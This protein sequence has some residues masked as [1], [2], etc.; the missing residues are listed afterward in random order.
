MPHRILKLMG[1][2]ILASGFIATAAVAQDEAEDEDVLLEEITI[3]ATKREQ[4]IQDVPFT[5]QAVSGDDIERAGNIDLSGVIERFAGVEFRTS[6]PGTGAVAIRGI[7]ELNTANINGGTGA[8]VGL[9]VDEAPFTVAGLMPQAAVFDL[10][11][12]EVL[13]GP[14]GSLFGEG[15][16]GGTIRLVTN[17]PD[18]TK[19][20]ARVDYTIGSIENGGT[21]NQLNAMINIPLV[22]DKLAIRAVG[23]YHDIGGFIDRIKPDV[24]VNFGPGQ[25][26]AIPTLPDTDTTFTTGSIEEDAND[27]ESYGGRVQLEWNIGDGWRVNASAMFLDADRGNRSLGTL[28]R[29]R[30]QSTD[31]ESTDDE[32]QQYGL[33]I[34]K[35]T[36]FGTFLSSTSY[37]DRQIFF[38]QDQIGLVDVA[39]DFAFPL[40]TFVLGD[41]FFVNG[42]RSDLASG[43]EDFS[44]ELRFV[45]DF[46]GPFQMTLG[47]FYRNRD[48]TYD[49][50]T[51]TEPVTPA[52]VFNAAVGGPLFTE[53]GAGD[54]T[55]NT[56]AETQQIALFGEFTY[57]ITD[58]LT[59]LAGGRVFEEDRESSTDAF[60]V[61]IGAIPTQNF[62]TEASETLFTPRLSLSYDITDQITG[63][64][65]F[66]EGF[67]SGGQN[68]LNAFV[69]A[70]DLD[71]YLSEQVQTYELGLKSVFADGRVL[72]NIAGFY[73][74]W[75]NLQVVLAEGPGGAG[76][77]LGNA[78]SARS[79]G[80][81]AELIWQVSENLDFTAS[82]LVMET[83]IRDSVLTVPDPNGN[84]PDIPV[85]VGTDIPGTAEEQFSAF[86]NYSRPIN[87]SLSFFSRAAISYLGGSVTSLSAITGQTVQP[88]T[89]PGFTKV[90][91]RIGVEAEKWALSLF[92]DNLFDEDIILGTRAG[93]VARD[94]VT[95]D[96]VHV[97]GPPRVIGINLRL[98]Y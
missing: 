25:N 17:K 31:F 32:L 65:T 64:A 81:D 10:Q 92:A 56:V 69:P 67:R 85:P 98:N 60:G 47:G 95:G 59:L 14:Q 22:E 36:E 19:F 70:I 8:A 55:V 4:R 86:A 89:Q 77:V 12:V 41:P 80:V 23:F 1:S 91:F 75:T 62:V 27:S 20:D 42:L 9:Y 66:S 18:P 15:S 30:T 39:N 46:E 51:R 29:V 94:F 40:S 34:E 52:G 48:F 84:G 68:D 63:Y 76:E 53:P 78:G 71:S 24:A 54:T 7:A 72:F 13:K 97:L 61:F 5:V 28:D 49:F 57:E 96:V 33:V 21:N 3:T 93:S 82:A 73:N 79:Y 26:S 87:D 2:T 58:R 6:Q 74:D 43:T 35:E 16:L 11:R 83:D 45:S 90:D 50:A 88:P 37:F 44:Q 38:P